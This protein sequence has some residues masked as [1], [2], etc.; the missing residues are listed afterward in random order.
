MAEPTTK[1][2]DINRFLSGIAGK[3]RK[4]TIRD[5]KCMTCKGEVLGFRDPLSEKE[6]T[7]S[8]LCQVCQDSVFGV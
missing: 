6:Y 5:N 3:D 8:G 1:S 4:E 2:E 7:I